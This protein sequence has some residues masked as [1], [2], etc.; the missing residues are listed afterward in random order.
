MRVVFCFL[1]F[2]VFC[3]EHVRNH[4][5]GVSQANAKWRGFGIAAA[6]GVSFRVDRRGWRG[7]AG[8]SGI[9]GLFYPPVACWRF[10]GG[11]KRHNSKTKRH[12]LP[13]HR[14]PLIATTSAFGAN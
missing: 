2:P 11:P 3:S 10:K 7:F 8:G 5:G 4:F 14:V 13:L 6:A 1:F 12:S 9:G